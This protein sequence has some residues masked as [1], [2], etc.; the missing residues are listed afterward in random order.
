MKKLFHSFIFSSLFIL[1]LSHASPCVL[2]LDASLK[3]I[4][5]EESYEEIS[6]LAGI[7]EKYATATKSHLKRYQVTKDEHAKV[8]KKF[9]EADIPLFFP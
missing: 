3:S 8:A 1:T 5:S 2:A 4:N 6:A 9:E 7:N